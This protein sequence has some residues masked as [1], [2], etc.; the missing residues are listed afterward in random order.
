MR[1]VCVRARDG[2]LPG[3][4]VE[5]PDGAEVSGVWFALEGSPGAEAAKNRAAREREA[6]AAPQPAPDAGEQEPPGIPVTPPPPVTL[7]G[8]PDAPKAGA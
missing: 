8:A 5:V 3:D 1:V 7:T 2:L 4:V 6:A